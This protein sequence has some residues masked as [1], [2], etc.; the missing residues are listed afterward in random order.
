MSGEETQAKGADGARRAKLWLESTTRVNVQ[1]VNPHPVAVPKLTFKWHGGSTFSFDLGGV[2]LGEELHGQEFLAE[3]KKYAKPS[4]QGT[5]YVKYL[6]Q[7]YRAYSERPDRCDNFFWI[8]WSPF[9]SNRWDE[10]L[11]PGYVRD[12]VLAHHEKALGTE[13][14]DAA[15]REIS[16]NLCKDVADRLWMILLTD[17]QEKLQPTRLHLGVIRKFDTERGL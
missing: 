12:A 10:L 11:T 1:W 9:S 2:L 17:R 8:T 7:C 13:N 4:D 5:L 6:A 3:C 16:D 14:L 15:R